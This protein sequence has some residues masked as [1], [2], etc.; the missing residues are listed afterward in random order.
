VKQ[1]KQP[2]E[3]RSKEQKQLWEHRSKE[4]KKP[5]EASL[6]LLR[7]TIIAITITIA[8]A[9]PVRLGFVLSSCP[10]LCKGRSIR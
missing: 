8:I 7:I 6:L 9:M 4:K 5:V 2:W 10:S 1:Q 3:H